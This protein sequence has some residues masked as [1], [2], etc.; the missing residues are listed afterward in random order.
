MRRGRFA[1][2]GG[3]F[4]CRTP[5][6]ERDRVDF[7]AVVDAPRLIASGGSQEPDAAIH[8]SQ[9]DH[10]AIRTQIDAP[11]VRIERCSQH[12]FGQQRK[13]AAKRQVRFGSLLVPR[14]FGR[15]QHAAL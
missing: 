15:E 11:W 8:A 10:A 6:I 13:S 3:L 12:R 5:P 14:R 9:D 1:P 2:S 4:R 7:P